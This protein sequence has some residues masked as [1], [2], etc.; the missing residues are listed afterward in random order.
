ML[1]LQQFMAQ[2]T[3]HFTTGCQCV[4]LVA[5]WLTNLG[6]ATGTGNA[7][8]Y[9]GQAIAGCRWIANVGN[10]VPSPGDIVCYDANCGGA[11]S[12]GHIDICVDASPASA[13]ITSF[14]QNWC[15]CA[16]GCD[17]RCTCCSSSCAPNLVTH[18]NIY[19]CVPGWQHPLILGEPTPTP[20]PTLQPPTPTPTPTPAPPMTTSQVLGGALLLGGG[21]L[22]IA[23]WAKHGI[24]LSPGSSGQGFQG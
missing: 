12:L 14:G 2:Y 15:N 24:G 17:T 23:R 19:G 13:S 21:G 16:G 6:C 9:P 20:T 8:N 10:L 7:N 22:L 3:G 4:G 18:T 1:S 11:G 5:T